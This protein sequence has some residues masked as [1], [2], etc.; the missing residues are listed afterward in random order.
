MEKTALYDEHVKANAKLVAFAGYEMPIQY[1]E[2]ILKEHQ[3]VREHAGIFD[4]SHMGQCILK[5]PETAELLS[6]LT[7]SDITKLP[8][9]KAK[10]TVLMHENGGII[11]DLIISRLAEDAF[12]LV[13]NAAR[14]E[15][16]VAWIT[17]HLKMDHLLETFTDR[18]LIALQGPK[19]EEVLRSLVDGDPAEMKFMSVAAMALEDG[20]QVFISRTGYT[21][22][23]GFE[24]SIPGQFAG[25]FWQHLMEHPE[26]KP[27]GLGARDSLRLEMGFPLYGHDIDETTSPIE[28]GLGWV[29]GK[30]DGDF[31]GAARVKKE[32]AEGVARK[33]IGLVLKDKGV[34]REGMEILSPEGTKIGALTSAG[35]APSLDAAIGMGYVPPDY[36]KEGQE[37]LVAVRKKQLKAEIVRLPFK[38]AAT[39]NK[40]AA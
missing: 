22:E 26:V 1:E 28:A 11:D 10:Y 15:L 3:W 16:D 21:G 8:I 31:I 40:K 7:P 14:K 12:Y 4:V 38:P 17:D 32:K 18:A 6:K 13:I 34:A 25:A 29:M 2:G 27:I 37:L 5:G 36:A 23:D 30:Y 35:F 39:K 24:I 33:R 20:I 19:A 9:G